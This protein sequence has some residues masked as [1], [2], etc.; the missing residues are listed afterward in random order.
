VLVAITSNEA[1]PSKVFPFPN[2]RLWHYGGC[3][4]TQYWKKP[5]G[6]LR[7]NLLQAVVNA[8]YTY[9][10]SSQPI[11]GGIAFENFELWEPFHDRQQFIFGLT[12]KAP[13]ELGF[14]SRPGL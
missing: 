8:R 2:S 13:P 6:D 11:P 14:A 4:V 12:R 1:E 5:G 10:M 7:G 3:P 9:W